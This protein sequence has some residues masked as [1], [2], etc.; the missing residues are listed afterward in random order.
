MSRLM[1]SRRV[2]A[3]RLATGFDDPAEF[4]DVALI[5]RARYSKIEKGALMAEPEELAAIS[6]LTSK[7]L[8]FLVLGVRSG[9]ENEASSPG[10]RR[11]AK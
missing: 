4:A 3:A 2:K 9:A 8:D 11:A 5:D 6:K 10:P 7:S 1:F